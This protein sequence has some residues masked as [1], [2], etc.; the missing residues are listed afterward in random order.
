MKRYLKENILDDLKKDFHKFYYDAFGSSRDEYNNYKD[1]NLMSQAKDLLKRIVVCKFNKI[2]NA[3]ETFKYIDD[4]PTKQNGGFLFNG[5]E[6]KYWFYSSLRVVYLKV[7]EDEKDIYDCA[8]GKERRF[9]FSIQMFDK[10]SLPK[11]KKFKIGN[12][13]IRK[14]DD[15][16]TLYK[17]YAYNY[18]HSRIRYLIS[19]QLNIT[20]TSVN[21]I[22]RKCYH[23]AESNL[24]CYPYGL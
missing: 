16:N 21:N 3:L 22:W 2:P 18:Y 8:E 17:I 13:V 4:N 11:Q 10:H 24:K 19:N 7:I 15:S 12:L 6:Y 5:V 9:Q 1:P 23:I 20:D 14:N